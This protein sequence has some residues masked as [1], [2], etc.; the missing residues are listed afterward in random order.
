MQKRVQVQNERGK[1]SANGEERLLPFVV[2]AHDL[3]QHKNKNTRET[4]SCKKHQQ[5]CRRTM[6]CAERRKESRE[7]MQ[8][9]EQG[10]K[11]RQKTST[12]N[13]NKALTQDPMLSA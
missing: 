3:K 7:K 8:G 6:Q 5:H 13:K 1:M 10:Q 4:T 12:K 2:G 9:R 11:E